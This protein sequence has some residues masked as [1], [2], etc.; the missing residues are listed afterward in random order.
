MLAPASDNNALATTG[1]GTTQTKLTALSGN[2]L[3]YNYNT[4][5]GSLS[6]ELLSVPFDRINSMAASKNGSFVLSLT[7]DPAAPV[8]FSLNPAKGEATPTSVMDDLA[9]NAFYLSFAPNGN[10][11]VL[12]YGNDR[13]VGF[14]P[15]NSFEQIVEFNLQTG[16][17]TANEQFAIGRNG[18]FYLSDGLGGGSTYAADGA[19]LNSFS[20]PDGVEG[21][22]YS[23]ASYLSADAAGRVYVCDSETGFHQYQ[24]TSVVPEPLTWA[25]FGLGAVALLFRRRVIRSEDEQSL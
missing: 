24:D 17:T 20:L 6:G 10:L 22:I 13:M 25:L 1:Q 21:D 8:I 5:S 9:S 23:G 19:Y 7:L 15:T 14:D 3:V 11:Y 2:S 16:L 12:D 18:N 4:Q